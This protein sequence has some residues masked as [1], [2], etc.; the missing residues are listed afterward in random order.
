SWSM[1]QRNAD[2]IFD[3][4]APDHEERLHQMCQ[5]AKQNGTVRG[6]RELLELWRPARPRMR[7]SYIA[8]TTTDVPIHV[9]AATTTVR[10]V[11][12]TV[13]DTAVG[14]S[15]VLDKGAC[16]SCGSFAQ[17][18][19]LRQVFD[20]YGNATAGKNVQ[21]FQSNLLRIWGFLDSA[22]AIHDFDP[23]AALDQIT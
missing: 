7:V 19:Q 10:V 20:A 4:Y 21:A 1:M 12:C 3:R 18:R 13:C 9:T 6:Y 5:H 14:R 23:T 11:V 22:S 16:P 8:P 17:H 2:G 15:A